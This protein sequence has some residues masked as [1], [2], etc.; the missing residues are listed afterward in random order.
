MKVSYR[1]LQDYVECG[2]TPVTELADR[3]TM[4]GL[5][6]EGL[7]KRTYQ[8]SD[9]IVVGEILEVHKH[10]QASELY[11][12]QVNIGAESSIRVVCGAPNTT[13]HIKSPV[14]L[15][16]AELPGG[17]TVRPTTIRGILSQGI[18]CAE[19][20]LGISEDHRGIMV[21]ST[22]ISAG[23]PVSPEILGVEDDTILEIGLTPNRGDCLSHVGVAR[24]VATLLARRLTFPPND[25]PEEGPPAAEIASVTIEDPE[26]CPRYTASMMIGVTIG[27][28]PLWLKRRVEQ[29]GMRSINNVVDVTNFVMLELGQPLHAFD[30][31]TLEGRQII[32]RRAQQDERFTTLDAVERQLDDQILMIADGQRR[33]VGIAGVMGGLNSE[34]SDTTTNI[35][36]E[37]A[38]FLPS[39]IRKTSKKLGLSTEASYRFER[40]IDL[41]TVDYALRRATKLIIE[42]AG[43]KAAQGIIDNFPCAYLPLSVSLRFSR[44]VDIL[45][46]QID[47]DT[48]QHIL[49]TLGFRIL[50]STDHE[51]T[52]EVPSYRPD[53]TREIDLIEEIGRIYNYDNIPTQFPSGEIPSKIENPARDTEKIAR[54]TLLSQGLHEVINYSFFD[55]ASLMKL[56]VADQ[57]P[58]KQVIPLKN[59]LTNEQ[60][61]L[62]T[63]TIPGL[64]DNVRLNK[65]NRVENLRFFEIGRVFYQTDAS[66]RL[67]DEQTVISVVLAGSRSD[68]SWAEAQIPVDFYDLK[69]IVENLC[70]RVH[71]SAIFS[72]TD[73]YPFLH[74]GE[75]AEIMVHA[76]S[77]GCLG[78]IHPKV[79]EQFDLSDERIYFC[80]LYVCSLVAGA[81]FKKTFQPLPKFPAV[82]RD[83]AI[84]VPANT[85][86][87]TDIEQLIQEKGAPLLTRVMLFDRYVG[88]Q[89]AEGH[90]G[91]TYSL[92]YRSLERTLTD[93]EVAEVHHCIIDALRSYFGI[94]IR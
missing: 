45:G 86:L 24:E 51:L 25:Y 39:S 4:A 55:T 26:L 78:R 67:P 69:G 66:T 31:D 1:W 72:R 34:I 87:A 23:T 79:A 11:V 3:L 73:R 75:A 61:S 6:V 70:E 27:P 53:V 2:D 74:P 84:V 94:Q 8:F 36:L 81:S 58:Y 49:S 52:V 43:G 47:R 44:V 56:G 17:L 42:L 13:A 63:T 35:L 59:P 28:S 14:A 32:V 21:L 22:D 40:N 93:A 7:E 88:P 60:A 62:R 20:E 9:Q 46:I 5:E 91:F 92:E 64:L 89:I 41:L 71:V 57:S 82:F 77:I 83:L 54:E 33:S 68:K 38:Y 29:V 50:L 76:R 15:P 30:L 90:V 18:L 85:I 37:S 65:S 48:I 12:C 10:P 19:D 80:E 16:G